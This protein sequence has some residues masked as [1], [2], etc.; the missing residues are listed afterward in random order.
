MF[1]YQE[2]GIAFL[3]KYPRAL[4]GDDPGLGKTRQLLLAAE[5]RTLVIAP[6]MLAGVWREEAE[7]WA[8]GLDM[9][10]APYSGLCEREKYIDEDGRNRSRVIPQLREEWKGRWDT[11][12]ADEA[13]YLKGR[14]TNWT[15]AA[16]KLDTGRLLMATGTPVPNY[17]EDL[18]MLCRLLHPGDPRWRSYWAWVEEWFIVDKK[19]RFGS[20]KVGEPVD[21]TDEGWERFVR[22]NLG[23]LYLARTRDEVGLDL[24]PLHQQLVSVDMVPAQRKAYNELKK[25]FLTVLETSGDEVVCWD[26][27]AQ[28]AAMVKVSTGLEALHPDEKGSGKLDWVKEYLDANRGQP[29]FLACHLRATA[30][31]L[32]NIVLKLKL[33]PVIATGEVGPE[34]RF[35]NARAFQEGKGDVLV[36]TI[37]AL[38]EGVTVTRPNTMIFVEHSWRPSRN[39]QIMR[40]VHRIGQ[41][42]PVSVIHLLTRDSVDE[43]IRESLRAKKRTQKAIAAADRRLRQ[44]S[45]RDFLAIA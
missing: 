22:E 42:R 30:K 36:A 12:V 19:P 11:V 21:D 25:D 9:T 13:H 31:A 6:A 40:R 39:E 45:A 16:T 29:V 17:A 33:V 15:Q 24:P 3:R 1:E 26:A 18:F 8:P 27:G 38:A 37:E 4:L 35:A 14:H 23:E 5:G 2:E 34:Q 41:T 32:E 10:I 20:R 44:M 7:K 28:A 43:V